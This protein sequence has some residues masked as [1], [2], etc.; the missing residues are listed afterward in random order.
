MLIPHVFYRV[1]KTVKILNDFVLEDKSVLLMYFD[2]NKTPVEVIKEGAFGG[3]YF[4]DI[5][6]S[7]NGKWYKKSWKTFDQLK[8][9]DRKYYFSSYYDVSV[10]KY[11]VKCRTSLYFGKIKAGLIK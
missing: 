6:S 10:T 9:I 8:N 5:Y 3:T 1:L 7:V 4:K 11:V 2:K